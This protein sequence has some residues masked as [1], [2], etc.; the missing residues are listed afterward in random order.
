MDIGKTLQCQV[1]SN[2]S[3]QFYNQPQRSDFIV[4]TLNDGLFKIILDNELTE[5]REEENREIQCVNDEDCH[6]NGEFY[7][8]GC[9]PNKC[10]LCI[11]SGRDIRTRNLAERKYSLTNVILLF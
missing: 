6:Q 1:T 11:S 2:W 7:M 8:C 10:G 9:T 3:T 5:P 4:F